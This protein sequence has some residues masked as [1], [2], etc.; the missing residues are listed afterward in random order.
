MPAGGFGTGTAM[1]RRYIREAV[2]VLTA[3]APPLA[4]AM[5]RI[6]RLA[7]VILDATLISVDRIRGAAH[8]CGKPSVTASTSRS[9][10]TRPD[11]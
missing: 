5:R 7:Y 1:A 3:T 9:S 4:Q 11:G 6:R 8:C 10:P 2:D